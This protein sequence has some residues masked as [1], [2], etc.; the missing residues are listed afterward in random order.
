MAFYQPLPRYSLPSLAG[1]MKKLQSPFPAWD[2]GPVLWMEQS[3]EY[4]LMT[5]CIC[6]KPVWELPQGRV[7]HS[8]LSYLNLPRL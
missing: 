1:V 8:G 2:P 3:R 7:L 6:P 4:L 5:V